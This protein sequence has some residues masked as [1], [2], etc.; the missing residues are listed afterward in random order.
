[1]NNFADLVEKFGGAAKMAPAIDV[2]PTTIRQWAFRNSIPAKHF[3]RIVEAARGLGLPDITL[4]LLGDLADG[5]K[6]KDAPIEAA[7][8]QDAA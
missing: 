6:P 1:M 2:P 7:P 3:N 4:Q 5:R 8:Q